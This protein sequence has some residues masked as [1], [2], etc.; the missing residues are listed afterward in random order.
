[1]DSKQ[2]AEELFS[3]LVKIKSRLSEIPF[4]YSQVEVGTLLYLMFTKDGISISELR[5]ALEVS[6]PRSVSIVNTLESKKMITKVTDENDK[7]KTIIYITKKGKEEILN[8]KELAI[9]HMS[10]IIERVDEKDVDEYIRLAK[11]LNNIIQE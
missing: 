2:K 8:K 7:R 6:M 1:M 4:E 9:E 5:D 10:K 11:K 3:V